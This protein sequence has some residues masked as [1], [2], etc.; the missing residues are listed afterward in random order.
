MPYQNKVYGRG[1]NLE[2]GNFMSPMKMFD[3]LASGNL[4]IASNL[5]VYSQILKNNFN[6]FLVT[7]NNINM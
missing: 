2:L 5:K 1:K 3:Y 4:I 6:S 7:S